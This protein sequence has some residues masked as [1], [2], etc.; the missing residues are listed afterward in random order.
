MK[1]LLLTAVLACVSWSSLPQ[2][3]SQTQEDTLKSSFLEHKPEKA[4]D[5]LLEY[6]NFKKTIRSLGVGL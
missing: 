4:Q 5:T 6:N 2:T 3:S 1:R